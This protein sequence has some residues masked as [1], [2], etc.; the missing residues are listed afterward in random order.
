[1]NRHV[2]F[3]HGIHDTARVFRSMRLDFQSR[4]W[5][6]HAFD[7]EP[8]NGDEPIPVLAE[9]VRAWIDRSDIAP[10]ELHLVGFSMGGVICRYYLQRLGGL[11]RVRRFVSLGCPHHGS[12]L[13]WI[14]QN[15][16]CIDLRPGSDL[17]NNLNRDAD[18]LK[19]LRFTSIWSKWDL[20]V[21]PAHSS[22]HPAAENIHIPVLLHP[23][24]LVDRRVWDATARVLSD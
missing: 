12:L 5:T 9:Q 3:V 24:M 16:G 6:T 22:V 4:G 21:L 20:M 19:P 2:L 7:L 17:L 15:P 8:A 14:P 13:A 11:G 1:M 23:W 18:R 10:N